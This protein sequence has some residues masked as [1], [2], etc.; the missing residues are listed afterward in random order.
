MGRGHKGRPTMGLSF[1]LFLWRPHSPVREDAGV[2][3][4]GPIL[5]AGTNCSVCDGLLYNPHRH[6]PP[7]PPPPPPLLC[8]SARA[9]SKCS[10]NINHAHPEPPRS[11]KATERRRPLATS[12]GVIRQPMKTLG[13]G[14]PTA[15]KGS[16]QQCTS[17]LKQ[18]SES[19]EKV[20]KS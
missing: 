15:A 18:Q 10:A 14:K 19:A 5:P 3:P 16:A 17:R 9:N 6:L 7:P 12:A 1:K 13:G 2:V 8:V 4:V 20:T 11:N